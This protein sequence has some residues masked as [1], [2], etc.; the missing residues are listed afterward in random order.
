MGIQVE[1]GN[2]VGENKVRW[3]VC[4]IRFRVRIPSTVRW[5]YRVPSKELKEFFV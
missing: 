1:P 4:L 5:F 3:S 2:E